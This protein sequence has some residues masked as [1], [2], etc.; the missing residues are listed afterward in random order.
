MDLSALDK[1]EKQRAELEDQVAKLRTALRHWQTWEIEYEGL[2]EEILL[3]PKTSSSEELF[4]AARDFKAELVNDDE[5]RSLL[6]QS[7]STPRSQTQ[8]ADVL[9]RRIDYVSRNSQSIQKQLVEAERKRNSLLL[10]DDAVHQDEAGLPVTEITEELDDEGNIISSSTNIP[11]GNAPHLLEV[12]EK[13]GVQEVLE[14]DG[15]LKTVPAKSSANQVASTAPPAKAQVEDS[16]KLGSTR[17]QDVE[18]W[19]SSKG[20]VITNN[21]S[22]DKEPVQ[23]PFEAEIPEDELEDDALLRREMIDYQAGLD[24][25][26]AIVAELELEDGEDEDDSFPV[27]MLDDDVPFDETD[28]DDSEDEWGRSKKSPFTE[29]YRNQML[30]LE[31]KHNAKGMKNLGPSTNLPQEVRRQLDLLTPASQSQE[32]AEGQPKEEPVTLKAAISSTASALKAQV[33]DKNTPNKVKK[34]VA[35]AEEL[36]IAPSTSGEKQQPTSSVLA[37]PHEPT[38]KLSRFRSARMAKDQSM[39]PEVIQGPNSQPVET[40]SR[41]KTHSDAVVERS[42][43]SKPQAPSVDDIDERMHRQEITMDYHKLRSRMMHREGGF[44]EERETE[45]DNLPIPEEMGAKRISR[46]KAARL[47]NSST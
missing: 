36:D 3:Q 11:A 41:E 21:P 22:L 1:V 28:S 2:K 38:K 7:L 13:T 26:G 46:F 17:V 43:A 14:S 31:K 23:K 6:G 9:S 44:L 40:R 33:S 45:Q 24:E 42:A 47:K 15:L 27:D 16:E 25:V 39:E 35:F 29:R 32:K 10:G 34:S 37:P 20:S 5:I 18:S 4:K 19:H 8:V 30:A 12:L